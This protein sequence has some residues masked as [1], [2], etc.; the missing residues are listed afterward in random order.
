MENYLKKL[1]NISLWK[2]YGF[3]KRAG[4]SVKKCRIYRFSSINC[5]PSS[6]VFVNG[7]LSLGCVGS[8]WIHGWERASLVMKKGSSFTVQGTHTIYHNCY[9]EINENA[10]VVIGDGGY[11][12]HDTALQCASEITIGD[13][14]YI[15]PNV[16]IQDYDEHIVIKEGYEPA[17][18][19][20]IGNHV[21][22]SKNV[23][24]LKGVTIG[25]HSVIAAGAVVTK[26]VPPHS[27]VG[28]VPA[29]I[30]DRNIDW[31]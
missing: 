23:T 13:H 25:D 6:K 27:L 26:D 3:A 28:G 18:P 9:V 2:S 24:I 1:Y 12:N 8:G 15:A 16:S 21:W 31:E 17:K 5:H 30:L 19:I 22:I 20:H 11:F 10:R 29:K 7:K 4:T 14:V